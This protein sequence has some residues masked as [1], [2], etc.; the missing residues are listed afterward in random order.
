MEL[1]E[2]TEALYRSIKHNAEDVLDGAMPRD[3]APNIR[4]VGGAPWKNL[5]A[6]AIIKGGSAL[7]QN[8]IGLSRANHRI[9]PAPGQDVTDYNDSFVFEGSDGEGNLVMTRIGFREGGD[10]AEMWLWMVLDGKKYWIPVDRA[11]V[12][13]TERRSV[14]AGELTY[15]CTDDAWDAW[16]ITYEGPIDPSGEPCVVDLSYSRESAMY[17][18]GEHMNAMT[19]AKS[20]AEMPWSKK[21][22][23]R[24]GSEN[25]C[26]IEQGGRLR[27]TITVGDKTHD[28][29]ILSIR[30][31]SW[32][33]RRWTFI[34]RYIWNLV[35]LEE[36]LWIDGEPYRYL[37]C[38]TVDYGT[39]FKHLVTGWI[40][41]PR[42][43]R[44][45]VAASDM[46]PLGGD[47]KIPR[48]FI[49]E[50]RPEGGPMLTMEMERSEIE[51]SWFCQG[52]RFEICEAHC[53]ATIGGIRG[54]GMSEF[55]FSAD[56]DFG[57]R[58]PE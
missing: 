11:D 36:D 31:H 55:G 16:R 54:H 19:F 15:L 47:G 34:N 40:A 52:G 2:K 4:P 13:P 33:K 8:Q 30:D 20:M 48:E 38:S 42:S 23:E 9:P 44:P 10:R 37:V 6:W 43:V 41:G 58:F 35:S 25:Q 29:D 46:A 24:L 50:L 53:V 7:R 57:H 39:T 1:R 49:V 21:Y 22:F 45:I 28:L 12:D 27:G 5:A 56:A 26:R 18:S 32:G 3:R 17:H 14:S 51:H